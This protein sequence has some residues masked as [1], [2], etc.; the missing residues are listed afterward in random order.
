LRFF[1]LEGGRILIDGQDIAAVSQESLRTQISM[2]TQDTSLL[3]RSIR[4][5]IRYGLP[6]ATDAEVERAAKLAHAD[7]FIAT[8]E[9][10]KG[11][12]G[13]DAQVGE[14]GVKLSGGQRQRIS[15]ARA[16]LAE[17]RI[18]ILDE[19][20]SSLDSESEQLI[21]HGLSYLMQG[22]TTFVIAH[23]LSTIRHATR[24]L[25][26]DNGHVIESGTFDELVAKGGRFAELARAQFMVQDHARANVTTPKENPK[27]DS[28]KIN[29]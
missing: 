28:A 29:S 2:V 27:P 20:T 1:D 5:N 14:R 23:R 16:I 26:F 4:E 24:I 21:Q 3:H 10:W 13:Y 19:A 18:L 11:R 17:P 9:D 22:R 6:N 15:I 7:E 8:L 25:M 12:H